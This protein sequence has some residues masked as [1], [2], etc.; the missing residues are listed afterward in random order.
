MPFSEAVLKLLLSAVGYMNAN[1]SRKWPAESLTHPSLTWAC[2][3]S[4]HS[5]KKMHFLKGARAGLRLHTE[6]WASALCR[7]LVKQR[8][9]VAAGRMG[10]WGHWES[11]TARRGTEVSQMAKGKIHQG[12]RGSEHLPIQT[13]A[14][15]KVI[16]DPSE[17]TPGSQRHNPKD[18]QMGL[19]IKTIWSCLGETPCLGQGGIPRGKPLRDLALKANICRRGLCCHSTA[20]KG[21]PR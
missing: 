6:P 4:S 12:Q 8:P 21:R 3:L 11:I 17:G 13:T 9:G 2:S 5:E 18:N 19:M 20:L 1:S 15:S 10:P 16:D 7:G 14:G